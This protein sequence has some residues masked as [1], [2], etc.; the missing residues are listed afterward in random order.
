MT[1]Y[2]IESVS[3]GPYSRLVIAMSFMNPF[4]DLTSIE[5]DLL[6]F[7]GKVLFDLLFAVGPTANRFVESFFNGK[8]F[9]MASV[10]PVVIHDAHLKALLHSFYTAYPHAID[11]SILSRWDRLR[12]QKGKI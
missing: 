10:K 1:A 11:A 8:H 5:H 2:A 4:D 7:Q 6:G 12:L 3:Y 9:V